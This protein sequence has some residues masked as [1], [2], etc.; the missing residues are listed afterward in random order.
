MNWEDSVNDRVDDTDKFFTAHVTTLHLPVTAC[1]GNWIVEGTAHLKGDNR[2]K[3]ELNDGE[4]FIAFTQAR[5]WEMGSQKL[6]YEIDVLIVHK[7]QIVWIFPRKS[8]APSAE[9]PAAPDRH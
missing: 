6:A 8:A 2:L 3:D 5:V 7:N 4:T 1:I 9:I